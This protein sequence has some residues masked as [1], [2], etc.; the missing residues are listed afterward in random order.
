MR[1]IRLH[2]LMPSIG[3]LDWFPIISVYVIHHRFGR[4]N[5]SRYYRVNAFLAC[6]IKRRK[7]LYLLMGKF[8][9]RHL[10]SMLDRI[11]VLNSKAAV[12]SQSLKRINSFGTSERPVPVGIDLT[13]LQGIIENCPSRIYRLY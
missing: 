5:V 9:K 13:R 6:I 10:R 12:Q 8:P 4:A 3:S 7:A 1:W 11:G 2:F